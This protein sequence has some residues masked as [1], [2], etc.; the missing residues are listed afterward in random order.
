VYFYKE[1]ILYRLES[2]SARN[3]I[4]QNNKQ[5]PYITNENTKNRTCQHGL[6]QKFFQWGKVDILLIF[7]GCWR[8]KCNANG[9]TQKMSNVMATVT[10]NVFPIRK[11]Y[12]E[13][14]FV[15]VRL[16]IL[17]TELAEF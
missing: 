13:K 14:I 9:R 2:D 7:S 3:N 15:L 1:K 10:Y 12:T 4:H 5:I 16:D 6:P 8:S 17:K 11:F